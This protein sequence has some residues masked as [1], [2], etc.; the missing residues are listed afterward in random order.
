[1]N[2]FEICYD[3]ETDFLSVTFGELDGVSSKSISLNDF[4]VL[5]TD[6]SLKQCWGI[7]FYSFSSLLDVSETDLTGLNDLTD[8][9]SD[10]V[11][12]MLGTSPC[13]S[14]FY[15]TDSERR[16]ARISTPNLH[17]LMS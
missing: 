16:L 10:L 3:S 8:A 13:K 6:M 14:F 1:M 9:Q 5:H 2:S 4:V 11:M 17:S 7:E 15:I 12:K